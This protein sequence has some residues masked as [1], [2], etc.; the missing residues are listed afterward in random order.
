MDGVED[1]LKQK[2]EIYEFCTGFRDRYLL[3]S[4]TVTM[5]ESNL[6][7]LLPDQHSLD[8][9]YF[10]EKLGET[11]ESFYGEEENC[12]NEFQNKI[13]DIFLEIQNYLNK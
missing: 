10:I 3:Y 1:F 2:I 4:D 13:R 5:I 8:F 7:T 11:C 6:V 12:E 9:V